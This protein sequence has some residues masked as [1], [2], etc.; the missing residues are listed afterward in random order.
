MFRFTQDLSK[1]EQVRNYAL[2]LSPS[3]SLVSCAGLEITYPTDL[4]SWSSSI[5]D[6]FAEDKRKVVVGSFHYLNFSL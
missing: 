3:S 2:P 6:N 4:L 5:E 1:S